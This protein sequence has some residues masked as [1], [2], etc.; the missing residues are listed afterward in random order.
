MED[1]GLN[2]MELKTGS[3]YIEYILNNALKKAIPNLSDASRAVRSNSD[4]S[5]E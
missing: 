4:R 3:A 2:P 5:D 1:Q